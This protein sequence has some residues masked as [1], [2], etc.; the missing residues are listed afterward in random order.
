[1][2]LPR[3]TRP[4]LAALALGLSATSVRAADKVAEKSPAVAPV[5]PKVVDKGSVGKGASDAKADGHKDAPKDGKGASE[6][7]GETVKGAPKDGKTAGAV[8]GDTVKGAPTKDGKTAGA[9]KGET[10]K[11]APT[12]D[13]KATGKGGSDESPNGQKDSKGD[14]GAVGKGGSDVKADGIKNGAAQKGS[15]KDDKASGIKGEFKGGSSIKVTD[16]ATRIP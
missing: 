11:G 5:A 14:K 2:R 6:V 4:T 8:K 16:K 10:V 12:K 3:R 7:K 1:M 13:G 15:L 9:V